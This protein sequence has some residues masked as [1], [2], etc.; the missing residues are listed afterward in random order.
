M[1]R[2]VAARRS[3]ANARSG[4]TKHQHNRAV[5]YVSNAPQN[6]AHNA[7]NAHHNAC[8]GKIVAPTISAT[9]RQRRRMN[10]AHTRWR[11][12]VAQ[13]LIASL[14]ASLIFSITYAILR[15]RAFC[16]N[17][18]CCRACMM[19]RACAARYRGHSVASSGVMVWRHQ[20]TYVRAWQ[21][22]RHDRVAKK[23]LK[24]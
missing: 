12:D 15:H 7:H 8:R 6:N 14:C 4:S 2:N 22:Q 9:R 21:W 5:A 24:W 17:K 19:R 10:A 18:Q 1:A 16:G 23:R 3:P 13:Q 11:I 20:P